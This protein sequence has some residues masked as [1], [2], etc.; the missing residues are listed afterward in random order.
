VSPIFSAVALYQPFASST[1]TVEASRTVTP[2]LFANEINTHTIETA[3]W[4]QQLLKILYLDIT[5]TY[6]SEPYT[7]I[8][9][10]V[11]PKYYFGTPP[12]STLQVTRVDTSKTVSFG[13]TCTIHEHLQAS[14]YYNV[15]E[16][17]SSQSAY[18]FST[19]QVGFSLNYTY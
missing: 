18:S 4:R 9:P 7:S 2:S 15:S 11:L 13:L 17:Q 16:V 14:V 6:S 19:S 8:A 10:G 1:I 12:A 3:G 5:G